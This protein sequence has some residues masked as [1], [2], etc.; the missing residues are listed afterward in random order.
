MSPD[1]SKQDHAA[2]E[3]APGRASITSRSAETSSP[4]LLDLPEMRFP[5]LYIWHFYSSGSVS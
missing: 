4:G 5:E 3:E 1:R 2:R